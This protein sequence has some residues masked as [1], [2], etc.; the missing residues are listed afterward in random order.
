MRLN[1]IRIQCKILLFF[2]SASSLDNAS[3]VSA[4]AYFAVDVPTLYPLASISI[5]QD[6]A[7]YS[8]D[9]FGRTATN[10]GGIA[11][12]P[13]DIQPI[14]QIYGNF[15]DDSFISVQIENNP[16]FQTSDQCGS[17]TGNSVASVELAESIAIARFTN[18][19]ISRPG[20]GFTLQFCLGTCDFV[21]STKIIS[22]SFDVLFGRLSI[23]SG[24]GS[25]VAGT[26]FPFQPR[27][28][29][30]SYVNGA[31][32]LATEYTYGISAFIPGSVKLA[33]R[34]TLW[35]ALGLV[36]YTDLRV[37]TSSLQSSTGQYTNF[38]LVFS[39]CYGIPESKCFPSNS[40]RAAL[41]FSVSPAAAFGAVV[42]AQPNSTI[43]N[44]PLGSVC[45]LRVWSI[46]KQTVSTYPPTVAIV[47]SFGNPIDGVGLYKVCVSVWQSPNLNVTVN[48]SGSLQSNL[49]YGIAIFSD[50]RIEESSAG[51]DYILRFRVFSTSS[52][53]AAAGCTGTV[54]T[55]VDSRPF[56][57]TASE[58]TNLAVHTLPPVLATATPLSADQALSAKLTDVEGN[59]ASGLWT[60]AESPIVNV[61]IAHYNGTGKYGR[62]VL[63]C[64]SSCKQL[65]SL[66]SKAVDGIAV[67][68]T[69]ALKS[70]GIY[71]VR[72][73]SESLQAY[74]GAFRV[75]NSLAVRFLPESY[76]LDSTCWGPPTVRGTSINCRSGGVL[77]P[78][79]S[80]PVFDKYDNLA[81]S[82]S[83]QF[84]ARLITSTTT[85][86]F[87][88][89]TLL[90]DRAG[91]YCAVYSMDGILTFTDLAVTKIAS[92]LQLSIG[93]FGQDLSEP[94]KTPSFDAYALTDIFVNSDPNQ[95]NQAG[96]AL[97][98][99]P[100]VSLIGYSSSANVT[101]LI[102]LSNIPV[103]AYIFACNNTAQDVMFS[104]SSFPTDK[105]QNVLCMTQQLQGV[106]CTVLFKRRSMSS[107][108]RPIY[109]MWQRPY[110]L[111]YCQFNAA[112]CLNTGFWRISQTEGYCGNGIDLFEAQICSSV[113]FPDQISP[114]SQ[115]SASNCSVSVPNTNATSSC[116]FT[117]VI[118][119][120]VPP[121][122]ASGISG[123]MTVVTV[124]GKAVFDNIR[125]STKGL[126]TLRFMVRLESGVAFYQD[127]IFQV[128]EASIGSITMLQNP[129]TGVI[130][131]PQPIPA[132]YFIQVKDLFGDSVTGWQCSSETCVHEGT[133]LRASIQ[134]AEQSSQQANWSYF[135]ETINPRF[136]IAE[137]GT[138]TGILKI[139]VLTERPGYF[140]I[141][142]DS[143]YAPSC[144]YIPQSTGADHYL[145]SSPFRMVLL[146]V[147]QIS[148]IGIFE[149][150]DGRNVSVNTDLLSIPAGVPIAV[151]AALYDNAG[152][153][154]ITDDQG[155][156]RY[157]GQPPSNMYVLFDMCSPN[158]T[159]CSDRVSSR[160]SPFTSGSAVFT[161]S[162]TTVGQIDL[163]VWIPVLGLESKTLSFQIEPGLISKLW[164]T[165][166]P[167]T[168]A[169]AGEVLSP[170]P[171]IAIFDQFGNKK[172]G[173]FVGNLTVT[174]LYTGEILETVFGPIST[175]FDQGDYYLNS[176]KLTRKATGCKA[177]AGIVLGFS[178]VTLDSNIGFATYV[179][180]IS[181]VKIVVNANQSE[182]AIGIAVISNIE[183]LTVASNFS[184]NLQVVDKFQNFICSKVRIT[185]KSRICQIGNTS[186]SHICKDL[187]P[188]P[189]DGDSFIV[190]TDEV[191]CEPGIFFAE[192]FVANSLV[193]SAFSNSF[194][195]S[196]GSAFSAIFNQIPLDGVAEEPLLFKSVNG[197]VTERLDVTILDHFG[198][199]LTTLSGGTIAFHCNDSRT[200]IME[201][202]T[203]S[204]GSI[205]FYRLVPLV[206]N[207]VKGPLMCFLA[208][209]LKNSSGDTLPTRAQSGVF[210]L[211]I[212]WQVNFTSDV[213]GGIAGGQVLDIKNKSVSVAVFDAYGNLVT[214]S[215][216]IVSIG[217]WLGQEQKF[218][219]CANQIGSSVYVDNNCKDSRVING[220]AKFEFIRFTYASQNHTL[221][222]NATAFSK[223]L[224]S[225]SNTFGV[226]ASTGYAIVAKSPSGSFVSAVDTVLPKFLLSVP[227]NVSNN[228]SPVFV[229][230]AQF[231]RES[232]QIFPTGMILGNLSTYFNKSEYTFRNPLN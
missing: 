225:S 138:G 105:L 188:F 30:E 78:L 223:R 89:G 9:E 171:I 84:T 48:A 172:S 113:Q 90:I 231:S 53:P 61:E 21:N 160:G 204:T 139:Q 210:K 173:I 229:K 120:V 70:S 154:V 119:T 98:P 58:V 14:L 22:N 12:I 83:Y 55:S 126:I 193:S 122:N 146:D 206:H 214:L 50:I 179:S 111:Y 77:R 82:G 91:A 47:D 6:A 87:C 24:V 145:D 164:I 143:T 86:V 29:V 34:T 218:L 92:N 149:L 2:I 134:S 107:G 159:M 125:L 103:S 167:A 201:M 116:K 36:Q 133:V 219:L 8:L 155:Y 198:N 100:T 211:N 131:T 19:G 202:S 230:L 31:F 118:S 38:T 187:P 104:T 153:Q 209:D 67:F 215:S 124:D 195:V 11:G 59:V 63:A 191:C 17:I 181:E 51:R 186:M 192:F 106:P 232:Y 157:N 18:L 150:L 25:S 217:D 144:T 156:L 226:K 101:S 94:A 142:I 115:W 137:E 194:Y 42:L 162:A 26:P 43:A 37:D 224:I 136:D 197:S 178:A 97:R 49:T 123:T 56:K 208:F 44:R 69:F 23:F 3:K 216:R 190:K 54:F 28:M 110:Y 183:N 64:T 132:D 74:S 228:F 221:T 7:F 135:E 40:M 33:G 200:S 32:Q 177:N 127:K 121:C 27:I 73:F 168:T 220:T 112:V 16:S 76:P 102:P 148:L 227:S 62:Y 185:I 205:S 161:F 151:S 180:N 46:C 184:V 108:S 5:T 128:S 152:K 88:H 176:L 85:N 41:N 95:A 45:R 60:A 130:G 163:I 65:D 141:H 117:S 10:I 39:S 222:V 68:T 57:I 140:T 196:S 114:S 175:Y 13:F 109:S 72:F 93:V 212:I 166:N 52:V 81:V 66:S 99:A 1:I 207:E 169:Y 96:C 20:R 4:S 174:S 71:S 203:S 129:S 80:G 199:I 15:S 165:R 35:P 79:L 189:Y 213:S 170:G 158:E 182:Q 147:T 75:V